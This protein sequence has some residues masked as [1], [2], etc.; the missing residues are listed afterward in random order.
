MKKELKK[1]IKEDEFL[2]GIEIAWKWFRENEKLARSGVIAAAVA[3]ALAVGL[4]YFQGKRE[5]GAA[6]AFDAAMRVYETPIAGETPGAPPSGV[7]PFKEASEKYTKAAAA[8]DGV[9]R[10]YPGQAVG[11]RARYYAALCRVELGDLAPARSALQA[12]AGGSAGLETSLAK[13]G[14]ADLERRGGAVD[15]AVEAYR[16]LA[17]DATLALPRDYVLMA[18]AGTLE[19][20]RRTEEAAVSYQN[21]YE[22]YPDS[23]YA[24]E[25]QHRAAYLRAASRG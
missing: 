2:S 6:A 18:L 21:V 23:V 22:R 24:G 20:A 9:E 14:L 7:V 1:Q 4:S 8:F 15:K 17:E 16:A 10:S 25:A 11:R 13:L 5:R 12:L 19:E 3:I